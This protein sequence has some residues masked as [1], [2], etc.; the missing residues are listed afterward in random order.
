MQGLKLLLTQFGLCEW[1]IKNQPDPDQFPI[2]G[3]LN[4]INQYYRIRTKPKQFKSQS[5]WFNLVLE[6]PRYH[7][8]KSVKWYVPRKNNNNN[9]A[10]RVWGTERLK[11]TIHETQ[12]AKALQESWILGDQD[13]ATMQ[14]KG[15]TREELWLRPWAAAG[16]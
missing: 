10:N 13:V 2:L 5:G 12:E 3:T 14:C 6:L 9:K 15:T 4:K 1:Q 8:F 11:V 7:K 16:Q